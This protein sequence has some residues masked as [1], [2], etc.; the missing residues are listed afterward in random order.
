MSIVTQDDY[1]P[2]NQ[3][4]YA[5]YAPKAATAGLLPSFAVNPWRTESDFN[6]IFGNDDPAQDPDYNPQ[7][8]F[9]MAN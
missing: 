6:R 7:H 2:T 5:R 9:D 3:D 1:A 4:R 8:E